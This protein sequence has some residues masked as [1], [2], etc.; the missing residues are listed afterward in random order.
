[1]RHQVPKRRLPPKK[2]QFFYKL[3]SPANLKVV[4][5]D[6]G[7]Q[8]TGTSLWDK[9]SLIEVTCLETPPCKE[10]LRPLRNL[11]EIQKFLERTAPD[12]VVAEDYAHASKFFNVLQA[13]L[14]GL[15]KKYCLTAKI[16]IVFIP[17]ATIK[18]Q[19]TGNARADKKEMI[20][21]IALKYSER[22]LNSHE[23]D[24]IGVFETY[25]QKYNQPTLSMIEH[26]WIPKK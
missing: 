15:V 10:F 19:I 2:I 14:V 9:N 20:R 22:K 18:K 4:S 5:F 7:I 23:T 21:E 13:E 25:Q 17:I 26:S 3:P 8:H 6:L 12:I 11:V 16:G 1:M 24:S